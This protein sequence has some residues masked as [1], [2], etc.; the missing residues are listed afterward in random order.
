MKGVGR[1]TGI[2]KISGSR[3]T[4]AEC[5]GYQTAMKLTC[6]LNVACIRCGLK[7]SS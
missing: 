1:G 5:F 3:C 4:A 7:V 6:L 2:G